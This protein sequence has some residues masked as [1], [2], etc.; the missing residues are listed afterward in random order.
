MVWRNNMPRGT[1]TIIFGLIGATAISSA[2]MAG[3]FSRGTADTDILYEDGDVVMRGGV[4]YVA[5]QRGYDTING[6]AGTDPNYSDSYTV[7]SVAG[8][9]Q[10]LDNLACAGTQTVAFGA[11]AS[12]GTQRLLTQVGMG[13][14][15]TISEG[16]T[17][18]Q[19]GLTCGVN[20][21]VGPGRAWLL[22]GVIFEKFK[23]EQ[24]TGAGTLS[25]DGDYVPGYQ[26]G[27]AYEV[28]EIALRGQLLYRSETSHNP[29][30]TFVNAAPIPIPGP[31]VIPPGTVMPSVGHGTMPQSLELK[32]QSGVAPGWLVFGSVKWTD[33]SVLQTL[34][35]E[36]LPLGPAGVN[37]LEYFW[38][39]GWTVS[40]G[41]GHKFN[42]MISGSVALTWDKGVSTTED[43][44]T[45]TWTLSSGVAIS[46][47]E[48]TE[49]RFGGAVSLL[50]SGSQTAS[51]TA[52][53]GDC[54]GIGACFDATVGQDISLA[55]GGSL[56]VKF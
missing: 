56:K 11:G 14:N 16:F 12:Y 5:P 9:L 31:A 52:A 48:N 26:L 13:Q 38:R 6:A 22:G 7:P 4:F 39:D 36:I 20:H 42:D 46:P 41:T 33:W 47:N 32:L 2:A 54:S 18:N 21:E 49:L 17:A 45:D 40:A 30:G 25:F 24:V 3:G 43:M 34:K 50:T 10:L 51:A 37:E 53:A 35:Y 23:Y 8:K 55:V 19:L 1:K 15:P 28:P 27:V 44:L 29:D